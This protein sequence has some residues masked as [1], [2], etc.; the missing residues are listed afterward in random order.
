MVT[1][2]AMNELN[3]W[4][5]VCFI[6]GEMGRTIM[7]KCNRVVLRMTALP[8]LHPVLPTQSRRLPGPSGSDVL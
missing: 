2:E 3:A 8:L 1:H 6:R 5:G 7:G 4:V